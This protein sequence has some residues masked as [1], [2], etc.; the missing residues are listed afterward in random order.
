MDE[1]SRVARRILFNLADKATRYFNHWVFLDICVAYGVVPNG[2]KL[3]KSAQIG[4]TSNVF[5]QKWS[6]I[7]S[8]AE[9]DMLHALNEEYKTSCL[10]IQ[11]K[12]WEKMIQFLSDA[13]NIIYV[14]EVFSTLQK[15]NN[16]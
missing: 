2:L 13:D 16:V 4:T 6:H 3:N 7:I 15:H 11:T 1:G 5:T 9:K 12:F 8:S 14:S 10:D